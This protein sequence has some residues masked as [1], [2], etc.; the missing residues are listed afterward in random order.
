VTSRKH[1]IQQVY[2][3]DAACRELMLLGLMQMAC[4]NGTSVE[5]PFSA[6]VIV[7]DDE[8]ADTRRLKYMEVY[9]V[10]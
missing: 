7:D 1:T 6:R 8:T 4:S 10:G 3:R 9:A 5:V 2:V